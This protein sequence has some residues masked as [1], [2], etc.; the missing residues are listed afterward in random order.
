MRGV[1][2][3]KRWGERYDLRLG[4]SRCTD[5]PRIVSNSHAKKQEHMNFFQINTIAVIPFF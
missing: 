1:S 2:L 4:C 3:D 5:F